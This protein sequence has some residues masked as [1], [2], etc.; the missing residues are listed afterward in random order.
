MKKTVKTAV[1]TGGSRGIGLGVVKALLDQ[2]FKVFSL[3]RNACEELS[4]ERLVTIK[5]DVANES[6]QLDAFQQIRE[7]TSRLDACFINA[8]VCGVSPLLEM[9]TDEW[10]RV[11]G[12][13]LNGA[14][15]SLR[16]A[17]RFMRDSASGG[18][19]VACCSLSSFKPEN[20]IV[21]YNASKAG[22]WKVGRVSSDLMTFGSME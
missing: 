12:T 14:F 15:Y 4:D 5:C 1:V 2:D 6:D 7:G 22:L 8:G 3:S 19:I 16:E 13:N 21:H 11:L 20:M 9:E 18:N 10:D 17:G